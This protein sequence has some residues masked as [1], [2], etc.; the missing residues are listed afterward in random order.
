MSERGKEICQAGREL[1]TKQ[2]LDQ[3]AADDKRVEDQYQAMLALAKERIDAK[4]TLYSIKLEPYCMRV[5]R[6]LRE[7]GF[8]EITTGDGTLFSWA[9]KRPK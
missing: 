9:Y 8:A 5:A 2:T 7:D 1:S 4:S 3:D 6:R